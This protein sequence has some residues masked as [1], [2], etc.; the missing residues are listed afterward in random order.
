MGRYRRQARRKGNP[1]PLIGASLL[2][3]GLFALEY[4]Q[5]FLYSV[6]ALSVLVA[7]FV[8]LKIVKYMRRTPQRGLVRDSRYISPKL[9][10]AV[11][12][13][14]MGRCVQCQSVSLLEYDHIIPLS[15]GGATSYETCR[16]YAGVATGISLITSSEEIRQRCHQD[17][18]ITDCECNKKKR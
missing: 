11:W 6:I 8:V 13:R 3:L 10:Q 1:L 18:R 5:L 14:D 2:V 4:W 7:L 16:F 15:K 9:R 12:T 17:L